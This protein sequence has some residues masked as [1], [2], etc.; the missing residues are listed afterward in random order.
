MSCAGRE[1]RTA[2]ISDTPM[3][4]FKM[5]KKVLSLEASLSLLFSPRA[6][7]PGVGVPDLDETAD[8]ASETRAEGVGEAT[9]LDMVGGLS[10]ASSGVGEE[11]LELGFAIV[12]QRR[13]D[14]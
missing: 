11:L 13:P 5:P 10:V 1:K 4:F 9:G 2:A 7:L 3:N 12:Q 14:E 6:E 8:P